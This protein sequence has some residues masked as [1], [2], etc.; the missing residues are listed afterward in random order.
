MAACG[1]SVHANESGESVQGRR[2]ASDLSGVHA[3]AQ[4]VTPAWKFGTTAPMS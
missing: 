3:H 4:M 1:E 2:R